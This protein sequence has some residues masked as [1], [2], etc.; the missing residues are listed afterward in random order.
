M[1]IVFYRVANHDKKED[2]SYFPSVP[3][4]FLIRSTKKTVQERVNFANL[5]PSYSIVEKETFFLLIRKRLS[6]MSGGQF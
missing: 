1:K 3:S 4:F 5:L 2:F 6:F